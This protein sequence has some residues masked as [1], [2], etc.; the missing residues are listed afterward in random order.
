[1]TMLAY[2]RVDEASFRDLWRLLTRRLRQADA[3]TRRSV[4]IEELLPLAEPKPA[5]RLPVTLW[6][7]GW[8]SA[9]RLAEALDGIVA[10]MPTPGRLD[11][12][13]ALGALEAAVRRVL[14]VRGQHTAARK[15]AIE[16]ALAAFERADAAIGGD[17]AAI[18]AADEGCRPRPELAA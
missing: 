5:G 9:A 7:L 12:A 8:I 6:G 15:A 14:A 1:M 13:K 16:A 3:L 4:P 10:T 2:R 18:F 11:Q 17:V